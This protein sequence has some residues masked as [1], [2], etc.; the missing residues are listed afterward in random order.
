MSLQVMFAFYWAGMIYGLLLVSFKI[1]KQDF[2]KQYND[3]INDKNSILKQ[4]NN[5][6]KIF[7]SFL[8]VFPIIFLPIYFLVKLQVL[9]QFKAGIR[10]PLF[11][12]SL[13]VYYPGNCYVPEF[14]CGELGVQLFLVFLGLILFETHSLAV[15]KI[16]AERILFLRRFS[17]YSL[18]CFV[19]GYFLPFPIKALGF[20]FQKNAD[21]NE[22]YGYLSIPV[23]LGYII[24]YFGITW[25]IHL[26]LDNY[27]GFLTP[28][29]MVQRFMAF[30]N[31]GPKR[32]FKPI[33]DQHLKV[34]PANLFGREL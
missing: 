32:G 21:G 19:F 30:F 7:L 26:L 18:S 28:D 17:T 23:Y 3:E 13:S 11:V 6:K 31:V 12:F 9:K 15:C 2:V 14:A 5:Y 22:M 20:P 27:G 33:P 1:Y 24:V 29:W 4:Y 16:R 25:W 8:G 34:K 10:E